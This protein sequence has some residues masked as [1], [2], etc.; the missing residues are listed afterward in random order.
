MDFNTN[1]T[2]L[3]ETFKSQYKQLKVIVDE[4]QD[5]DMDI[6]ISEKAKSLKQELRSI[7][8]FCQGDYKFSFLIQGEMNAGKK[9]LPQCPIR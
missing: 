8:N 7:L 3:N 5:M 4:L 9:H 6:L 2:V 1:L